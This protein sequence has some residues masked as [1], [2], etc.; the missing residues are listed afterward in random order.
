MSLIGCYVHTKIQ[1]W[2]T[3]LLRFQ[4]PNA[5]RPRRL[6]TS[7]YAGWTGS[8]FYW[9]HGCF[10][11]SGKERTGQITTQVCYLLDFEYLNNFPEF[12]ILSLCRDWERTRTNILLGGTLLRAQERPATLILTV[13]SG[14]CFTRARH[15]NKRR[16]E[17]ESWKFCSSTK[18]DR[19]TKNVS[20]TT[21]CRNTGRES[22]F[23][24]NDC[25]TRSR[26][27][28][29]GRL[30]TLQFADLFYGCCFCENLLCLYYA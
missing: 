12:V 10:N 1:N 5:P 30:Q 3:N 29:H 11:L 26:L 17:N 20:I 21:V 9:Y 24:K 23:S 16:T 15:V 18:N 6:R 13:T 4:V 8:N 22:L 7:N 25:H 27:L 2:E 19:N 14:L 28:S